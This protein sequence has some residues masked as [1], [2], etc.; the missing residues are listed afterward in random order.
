[1]C[2]TCCLLL[3]MNPRVVHRL[4]EIGGIS[5]QAGMGHVSMHDLTASLCILLLVCFVQ[6]FIVCL[7]DGWGG[8]AAGDDNR[9]A[10]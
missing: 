4:S 6:A 3:A 2:V 8:G 1:M 5:R 7:I 10:R 9:V